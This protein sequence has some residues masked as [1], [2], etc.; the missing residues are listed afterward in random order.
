MDF[1]PTGI[2]FIV[3]QEEAQH[4]FDDRTACDDVLVPVRSAETG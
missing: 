3:L 1:E 2:I 4:G